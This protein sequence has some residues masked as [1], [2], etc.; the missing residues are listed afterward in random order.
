MLLLMT[1]MLFIL[2]PL[3]LLLSFALIVFMGWGFFVVRCSFGVGSCG[4]GTSGGG[5]FRFGTFRLVA[6]LII[7]S[8]PLL[9]AGGATFLVPVV[10][11]LGTTGLE[12]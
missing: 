8:L 1:G 9:V 5:G 10:V 6:L 7:G 2:L 4:F 12:T 3:F 11:V